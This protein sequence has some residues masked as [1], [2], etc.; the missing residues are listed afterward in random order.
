M[1]RLAARWTGRGSRS[2]RALAFLGCED[3]SSLPCWDLHRLT[4]HWY[5]F[6]V[7]TGEGEGARAKRKARREFH[8][9]AR[10]GAQNEFFFTRGRGVGSHVRN[11]S[12]RLA[13]FHSGGQEGEGGGV[14]GS[15]V[16]GGG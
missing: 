2:L 10:N 6:M 16:G 14:G 13:R 1:M 3:G 7:D 9:P 4:T 12:I 11:A 15:R 8:T 5:W